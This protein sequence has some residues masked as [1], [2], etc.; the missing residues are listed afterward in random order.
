ME[1]WS[2]TAWCVAALL[3]FL[4]SF[5]VTAWSLAYARRR[6]L[7]DHPGQRRSHSMPTPRGGGI[8]LVVGALLGN[9]LIGGLWEQS[10]TSLTVPLSISMALVAAVGWIDD[11]RGL[12]AKLRFSVHCIA[13]I[14]LLGWIPL[15][16]SAVDGRSGTGVFLLLF[17]AGTALITTVWSINLHNFMDGIDGLLITQALFVFIALGVLCLNS[18]RV[19]EAARIGLFAAASSAFLPFNFPKARMFMGDVGSGVLGLLIAVSVGWSMSV[20]PIALAS[21]L[22]AC[23]A[24]VVDASATLIS[25]MLRGRRWYSAHRE[26]L[27]QWLVRS[28]RSHAQV[29]LIYLLWNLA[30]VVPVLFL[31]NREQA[32]D[33]VP[34]TRSTFFGRG[35]VE[36][37]AVYGLSLVVWMLGKQYCLRTVRRRSS[38]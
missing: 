11:H 22:I 16:S 3:V 12:S 36:L 8:G 26:H 37:I 25:R 7:L 27:Y 5:G 18:G 32:L 10:W 13:A 33:L 30:V 35:G 17:L 20:A 24:F 38:R 6:N 14:I 28:G 21:G 23:S 31:L 4:V 1:A 2:V 29:T 9:V 19:E 15:V 34:S